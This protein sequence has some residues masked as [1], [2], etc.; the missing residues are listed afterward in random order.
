[1]L[2]KGLFKVHLH[3]AKGKESHIIVKS[4][5]RFTRVC[6]RLIYTVGKRM[7]YRF[8]M[9]SRE[10]LSTVRKDQGKHLFSLHIHVPLR[11]FTLHKNESDVASKYF[12]NSKIQ[13][14]Y[15]H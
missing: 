9:G 10:I 14:F 2:Y 1:M 8:E 7:R 13:L 15:S 11:S 5:Y 3:C 12:I 4:E 6:L